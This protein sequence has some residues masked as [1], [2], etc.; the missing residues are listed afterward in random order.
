MIPISSWKS[1]SP[2]FARVLDRV[3]AEHRRI[4]LA[5][6]R[7]SGCAPFRLRSP[8]W[9]R[10][11]SC[12]SP[13]TPRRRGLRAGSNCGPRAAPARGCRAPARARARAPAGTGRVPEHLHDVRVLPP[14][15]LDLQVLVVVDVVELVVFDEAEDAVGGDDT[16]CAAAESGRVLLG[17]LR[18]AADHGVGEQQAGALARRACRGCRPARSSAAGSGGNRR[19]R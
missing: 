8:G 12:T 15:L 13:R 2:M 19:R 6:S 11:G 7:P 3:R 1:R 5:R 4:D 17:E 18:C 9:R 14:D 10:T 16:R